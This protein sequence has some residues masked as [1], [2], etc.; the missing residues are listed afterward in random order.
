MDREDISIA[1]KILTLFPDENI[2]L[3]KYFNGRKPD[4][5]FK[6]YNCTVEVD[7]EN[8]ENYDSND[9]KERE[10]MFKNH[11]CKIFWCNPN[12]PN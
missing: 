8:H 10:D 11:N 9:K 2:V 12:D 3:N 4:I 6:D 5:C 1:E 7:E